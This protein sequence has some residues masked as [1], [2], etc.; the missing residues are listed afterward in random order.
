[1]RPDKHHYQTHLVSLSQHKLC[2]NFRPFSPTHSR[3]PFL[4]PIF[5]SQSNHNGGQEWGFLLHLQFW[6]LGG[7][8]VTWGGRGE[9]CGDEISVELVQNVMHLKTTRYWSR[10]GNLESYFCSVCL[11][12]VCRQHEVGTLHACSI[13]ES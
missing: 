9:L 5:L 13:D 8:K 4:L 11:G 1:M 3:G 6:V 10:S 2:D 12:A 7:R